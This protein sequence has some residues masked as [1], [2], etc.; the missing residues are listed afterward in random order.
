MTDDVGRAAEEAFGGDRELQKRVTISNLTPKQRLVYNAIQVHPEAANDDALLLAI[1]WREEG[2]SRESGLVQNLRRVSRPETL[3]RR[4]R[5]LFNLGLIEYSPKAMKSRT[6]AFKNERDKASPIPPQIKILAQTI[7]RK[8]MET[9]KDFKR[10][11]EQT[12]L[13]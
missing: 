7:N 13:I 9:L 11:V 1:V 6:D 10:P 3:S 12:R 8:S 4:R 5:E 2:W